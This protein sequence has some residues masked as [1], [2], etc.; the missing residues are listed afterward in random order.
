MLEPHSPFFVAGI[1]VFFLSASHFKI[2]FY[3][4]IGAVPIFLFKLINL[5]LNQISWLGSFFTKG[6]EVTYKEKGYK[7][8]Y[9][10]F[11]I[12]LLL[13][14]FWFKNV[15]EAVFFFGCTLCFCLHFLLSLK[16]QKEFFECL[17]KHYIVFSL[18]VISFYI[19]LGFG[20]FFFSLG[21]IA[22]ILA[23]TSVFQNYIFSSNIVICEGEGEMVVLAAAEQSAS[24]N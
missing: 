6:F 8:Y 23:A 9:L 24:A 11:I 3:M 20:V 15:N 21:L 12:G 4:G 1:L 10:F 5:I 7:F 18:F 14:G 17:Y 2:N 22:D 19:L 13:I 16:V